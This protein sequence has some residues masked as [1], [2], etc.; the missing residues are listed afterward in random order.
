MKTYKINKQTYNRK[1]KLKLKENE[2][3][4]YQCARYNITIPKVILNDI[5]YK[6]DDKFE[7][8]ALDKNT[9]IITKIKEN[10]GENIMEITTESKINK[11][12]EFIENYNEYAKNREGYEGYPCPLIDIEISSDEVTL[13]EKDWHKKIS[14]DELYELTNLMPEEFYNWLSIID[15]DIE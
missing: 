13:H 15:F 11:I 4:N 10:K 12:K 14:I 5:D 3:V 9:I 2:Y 8:K 7:I 1:Y 6:N